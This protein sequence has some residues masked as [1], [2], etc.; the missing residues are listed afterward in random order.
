MSS[1][2]KSHGTHR[3][4]IPFPNKLDGPLQVFNHVRI[5]VPTY[6]GTILSRKFKFSGHPILQYIRSNPLS[7]KPLTHLGT[8]C[9]HIQP[10]IAT[11]GT[12]HHSRPGLPLRQILRK[13]NLPVPASR[14]LP[15]LLLGRCADAQKKKYYTDKLIHSHTSNWT[16]ACSGWLSGICLRPVRRLLSGF[17]D[18]PGLPVGR[19]RRSPHCGVP[20]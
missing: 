7:G 9:I 15:N 8:L 3:S 11:A 12:N 20:A 5:P 2:R 16:A 4:A 13:R 18:G 10:V 1:S 6:K 14:P 19:I 17:P